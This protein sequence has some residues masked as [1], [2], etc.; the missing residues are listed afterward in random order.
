MIHLIPY[1]VALFREKRQTFLFTAFALYCSSCV[2]VSSITATPT[3]P[4]TRYAP[5]SPPHCA[6]RADSAP[7]SFGCKILAMNFFSAYLR[8]AWT[9]KLQF[10]S[11]ISFRPMA[12]LKHQFF[13]RT[14][15]FLCTGVSTKDRYPTPQR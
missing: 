12:F 15:F 5:P 10:S 2:R 4:K 8:L 3:S 14:H 13:G 11:S 7:F 6:R 9:R 1:I